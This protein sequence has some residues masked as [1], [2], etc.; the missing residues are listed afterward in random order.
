MIPATAIMTSRF[1][2]VV[3]AA[4]LFNG[5][6]SSAMP[7]I[8][9]AAEREMPRRHSLIHHPAVESAA[10]P[11]TTQGT[12]LQPLSAESSLM[13]SPIGPPISSI[14]PPT[15]PLPHHPALTKRPV[16]APITS[17]A[18]L[19]Q[20]PRAASTS[21]I[22]AGQV[23][24]TT[25]DADK[26]TTPTTTTP[27]TKPMAAPIPG[28]TSPGS[29]AA[30]PTALTPLT[31]AAS[32][33]PAASAGN[34]NAPFSSGSRSALNLRQ[35]PAIVSLLQPPTP[36]VTTPPSPPPP[37]TPSSTSPPPSPS[38][39]N[40]T[41]RWTAN[42]EP[43]LAGYKIYVGRASGTYN[44]P[45]SPFQIGAVTSYTIPNLPKGQTY[46]FALSA[47]DSAGNE[48]VLSAE[49]SKSLY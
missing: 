34:G 47:Y 13:T 33:H 24:Q 25:A 42:R 5:I 23:T 7:T 35:N 12:I 30:A 28:M 2:L 27:F 15:M 44:F 6:Q 1:Q 46:F 39:A 45:G 36:D 48:S 29:V 18:T 32:V 37:S 3:L 43:D 14:T 21:D 26:G 17:P 31:G 8:L 22:V 20:P 41:F 38:T 11:A 4:I 19:S 16:T 40:V 9:S 10:P 49:I